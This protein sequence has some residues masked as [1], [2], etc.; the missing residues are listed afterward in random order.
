MY[1]CRI[2]KRRER[3]SSDGEGKARRIPL[4]CS[5]SSARGRRIEKLGVARC[6]RVLPKARAKSDVP[7]LLSSCMG[8]CGVEG[9]RGGAERENR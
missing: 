5:A 8:G 3:L 2:R 1:E 7:R 4:G 9:P 6:P